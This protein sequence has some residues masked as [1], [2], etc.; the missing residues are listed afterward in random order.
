MENRKKINSSL[1][2]DTTRLKF[3]IA[4]RAFSPH[5]ALHSDLENVSG[6][7]ES[8]GWCPGARP[9]LRSELAIPL[10]L[11]AARPY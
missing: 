1:Y 2:H 9:T 3:T 11:S 6:V 8:D 7:S 4:R 10:G 5:H